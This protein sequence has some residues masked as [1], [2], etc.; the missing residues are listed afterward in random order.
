VQDQYKRAARLRQ[1]I[2][3]RVDTHLRGWLYGDGLH[4]TKMNCEIDELIVE[5]MQERDERS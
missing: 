1:A 4:A 2:L 5:L 3:N